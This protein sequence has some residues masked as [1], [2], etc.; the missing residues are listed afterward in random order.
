[1]RDTGKGGSH[2]SCAARRA[3]IHH[4]DVAH[5]LDLW[6]VHGEL[7]KWPEQGLRG[8]QLVI[9]HVEPI[10]TEIVVNAAVRQP[11]AARQIAGHLPVLEIETAQLEPLRGKYRR[12][13][14]RTVKRLLGL[15]L[16]RCIHP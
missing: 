16:F 8:P 2:R 5:D 12:E 3:R 4:D 7:T 13:S 10:G 11:D 9:E 1:M 6:R 15:D 14:R